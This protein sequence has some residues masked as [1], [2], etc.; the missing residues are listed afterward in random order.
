VTSTVGTPAIASNPQA[1]GLA[2]PSTSATPTS[3]SDCAGL[4]R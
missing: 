1:T 4:T 2:S 3:R